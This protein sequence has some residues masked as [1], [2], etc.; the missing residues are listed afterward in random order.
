[1]SALFT[2][3]KH[4]FVPSQPHVLLI[5]GESNP[6][7]CTVSDD[8]LQ[9]ESVRPCWSQAEHLQESLTEAAGALKDYLIKLK[10]TGGISISS[11][12]KSMQNCKKNWIISK[13]RFKIK[14]NTF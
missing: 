10:E 11:S 5:S 9:L 4:T 2:L 3:H 7:A 13:I 12:P 1:M 6:N 8:T 14:K